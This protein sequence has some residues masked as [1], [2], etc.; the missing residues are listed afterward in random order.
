MI[1]RIHT[2][3][4]SALDGRNA[5]QPHDPPRAA[6]WLEYGGSVTPDAASSQ[7]YL[8]HTVT[9]LHRSSSIAEPDTGMSAPR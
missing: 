1:G 4:I 3:A 7:S 2:N 9:F 5:A 8:S 6:S